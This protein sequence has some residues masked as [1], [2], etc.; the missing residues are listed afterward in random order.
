MI[1]ERSKIEGAEKPF[2]ID[3]ELFLSIAKGELASVADKFAKDIV[4]LDEDQMEQFRKQL[5]LSD[6][7]KK[8]GKLGGR[9]KLPE[10]THEQI[11]AL[12]KEERQ[13]Y[14]MR[15]WKRNSRQR[16]RNAK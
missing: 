16:S 13:R 14:K 12:P 1:K 11:E 8:V 6:I 15:I 4:I 3:K 10:L 5:R 2:I 7:R 9:P